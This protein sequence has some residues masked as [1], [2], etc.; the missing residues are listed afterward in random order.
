MTRYIIFYLFECNLTKQIMGNLIVINTCTR[1][2]RRSRN[3]WPKFNRCCR[4]SFNTWPKFNRR[5]RWSLNT[6][7]EFNRCCRRVLRNKIA[8]FLL[9]F[10]SY[11][12]YGLHACIYLDRCPFEPSNDRWVE[13]YLNQRSAHSFLVKNSCYRQH[14]EYLSE[15]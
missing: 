13:T 11:I 1:C 12:L 5:C 15:S 14:N 10:F 3:T 7:S 8:Y 6:W 9:I 4:R 2:C